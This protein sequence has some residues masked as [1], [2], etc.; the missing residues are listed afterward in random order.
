MSVRP[1]IKLC[2]FNDLVKSCTSPKHRRLYKIIPERVTFV[3]TLVHSH[4]I[5]VDRF[6]SD[7]QTGVERRRASLC[8]LRSEY[9][10]SM[11]PAIHTISRILLRPSSTYEPSDPPLR[12]FSIIFCSNSLFKNNKTTVSSVT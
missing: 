8:N 6:N 10:C 5:S 3:H 7:P 2:N 1:C 12:I 11:C 9:R 4:T